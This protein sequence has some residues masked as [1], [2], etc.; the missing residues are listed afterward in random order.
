[1]LHGFLNSTHKCIFE[2]CRKV[3]CGKICASQTTR[4]KER[5]WG[6]YSQLSY[7]QRYH[8]YTFLKAGFCQTE[9]A[10]TIGVQKCPSAENSN[11]IKAGEGIDPNK[12]NN[13]PKKDR[14]KP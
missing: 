14:I 10:K 11:G 13:L 6:T 9:I 5:S 2:S 4:S 12:P 7:H 8:I 3:S 1:M